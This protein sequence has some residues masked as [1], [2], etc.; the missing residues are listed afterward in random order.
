MPKTSCGILAVLVCALLAGVSPGHAGTFVYISNADSR[1]IYVMKLNESDGSTDLAEKVPVNGLVMPMALSPNRKYLYAASRSGPCA[2][3]SFAIDPNDG[4]LTPVQTAPLAD[5]MAYLS[6]DRTGHYLFGASYSGN[7]ISVNALSPDGGIDPQPSQIIATGKNAHCITTDLS[8]KFLFVT[9]LGDDAILQYRFNESSGE[10]A[11]NTPPVVHTRKGAGPRHLVFHPDGRF[12]FS[13]NEL[14]GSVDTF[15]LDGAGTLT[16]LHTDSAMPADFKSSP[17]SAADLHLTPDG[18][19][20]YA[21]ERASNTLAAFR[22]DATRGGLTLIGNYPTEAQPRGFNIDPE[23]KYLLAAGQKSN[24]LSTY[25]I[26]PQ[27]GA[28]RPLSHQAL[29]KNPNWIEIVALPE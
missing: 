21:S 13:T 12:A 24:G 10:I 6:T 16:L 17:P 11:P 8:N 3:S 22:V 5:D 18:K 26:D 9:N 25:A 27:T 28:L 20:L 14:D 2:V 7:K 4:K 15:A 23:G 19:F 29:G 1:E